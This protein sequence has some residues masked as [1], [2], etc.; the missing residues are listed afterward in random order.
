MIAMGTR[1]PQGIALDGEGRL[2][3]VEEC[4]AATSSI[5]VAELGPPALWTPG[6]TE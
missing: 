2:W 5:T 1:N 6:V 3:T 4:A